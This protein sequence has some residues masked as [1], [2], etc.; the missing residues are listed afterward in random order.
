MLP[1]DM[2]I[3]SRAVLTVFDWYGTTLS[4][5]LGLLGCCYAYAR[6]NVRF[7]NVLI[8]AGTFCIL[9]LIAELLTHP[10][11]SSR[12]KPLKLPSPVGALYNGF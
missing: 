6:R 10:T 9:V 5:L 3:L 4:A 1:A 2:P 11:G 7:A 12:V 8:V